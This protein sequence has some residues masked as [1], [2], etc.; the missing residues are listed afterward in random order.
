MKGKVCLITGGNG[1][2]GKATSIALAQLGAT[3]ILACRDKERGDKVKADV[4]LATKNSNVELI[5]VDLSSQESIRQMAATFIEMNDRLDVLINNAAIYKSQ[6]EMTPDGLEL[7]FATNH[8][9]PFL[10]T[11]LL[12]DKL[13][14]SAPAR[15]LVITAPSTTPLDFDNLQGEQRFSSLHAFGVTKMCN[16]LFTY[17]LAGRLDGSGVTVNAV[18]PGLMKSSLMREAHLAMR[19]L[20]QLT[21]TAPTKVASWLVYLASAPEMAG[22][23]GKFFKDGKA[24][25]SNQ[26][27]HDQV[28]QRQLW[29]VSVALTKPR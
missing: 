10:L 19:W 11:N 15:V 27:S 16:L 25:E 22:V 6:R 28:I 18:H 2:L 8:I 24:I 26:Y 17:D 20:T 14:T 7:M 3:V 4:I 1:S 29:D 21:S 9:G 12:L 23:T 13:K 5:L